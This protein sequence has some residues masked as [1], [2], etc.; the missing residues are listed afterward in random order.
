MAIRRGVQK[1]ILQAGPAFILPFGMQ[2]MFRLS[3]GILVL[4]LTSF[5]ESASA[6]DRKDR[7]VHIQTSDGFFMDVDVSFLRLIKDSYLVFTTIGPGTLFE[8]N[9]IIPKAEPALKETLG[10]LT[11]EAFCNRH[12]PSDRNAERSI[13]LRPDMT[14]GF[15]GLKMPAYGKA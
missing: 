9:G 8:D 11:T 2:Q 5:P 12:Q 1:K 7:A 15:F 13:S 10:K 6:A 4:E 14:A 3:K